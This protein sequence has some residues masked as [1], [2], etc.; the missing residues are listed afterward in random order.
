MS[1]ESKLDQI[2]A[3]SRIIEIGDRFKAFFV[4]DLHL[5]SG[6]EADDF[7]PNAKLC[8]DVLSDYRQRGFRVFVLGDCYELWENDKFKAIVKRYPDLCDFLALKTT[9]IRGNHDQELILPESYLLQRRDGKKILL[10]H[11]HQGDFFN[12]E[13]YPLGRFFVRYLWRNLQKIGLKDPTTAIKEKNPRKHER[14]RIEFSDWALTREQTVIF[15]HTHYAESE[16]PHYW[17]CGAWVG[18]GGQ[19]VEMIGDEM[20]VKTFS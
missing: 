9:R 20:D 18:N 1:I 6:D 13:G 16:P 2:L 12:D 3:G 10:V 19:G 15:G 4:S 7:R 14:T 17:N 5:G 8:F 11:G